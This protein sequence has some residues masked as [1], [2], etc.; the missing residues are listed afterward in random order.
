MYIPIWR[1]SAALLAMQLFSSAQAAVEIGVQPSTIGHAMFNPNPPG[2]PAFMQ[3]SVLDVLIDQNQSSGGGALLPSV[4]VNWDTNTQFTLAVSAPPGQKFLVKVPAGRS[5]GFGGFLWWESTRGGFSPSG[6]VA[7]SFDG[8]EGTPPLFSSSDSVL[9]DSHGFFGFMDLEGTLVT[10]DFA[11]TTLRL[12]GTVAPQVTG[13]GTEF[14]IPHMESSMQLYYQTPETNDPGRFVFIVP[15]ESTPTNNV[16]PVVDW[17]RPTN[18]AVFSAGSPIF[19]TVRATDADGAIN[20]VDFF[21]GSLNLGRGFFAPGS[22]TYNLV[23]S[24]A[25]AGAFQLHAEA[26]DN[27]GGQGLSSSVQIVVSGGTNAPP[28]NNVLPLVEWIRPTNGAA[29]NAGNPILLTAQATDADGSINFVEFFAGSLNLGRSS[30][31]STNGIYDLM[32]SNAP[33]GTFQLHAEA[34][35]NAGARGLSPSVQILVRANTNSPP[36]NNAVPVVTWIRPTNGAVFAAGSSI[37]LT[38]QATDTDGTVSFVDFFAGSLNLGRRSGTPSNELY[39][40]VWSNAPAGTF[41]LHAEA[42]DNAGGRGISS[43]VQIVVNGSTNPPPTNNVLP[44][45]E[46]I[47]P[48]SGSTFPTG[49]QIFMSARASDADGTINFVEFFAGSVKLGRGTFAFGSGLYNF[50]WSNAP[51]GMFQLRAEAVDNAGGRGVSASAPIVVVGTNAPATNNLIPVVTWVRPTNGAT[52]PSGTPITLT[53]RATDADGFVTLVDFFANSSYLGRRSGS[54]TNGLY[55]LLWSN[56]PP[57]SFTLRAEALD[58]FGGRGASAPVQVIVGITRTVV[59][60]GLVEASTIGHEF[61]A[62]FF[63]GMP[64]SVVDYLVDQDQSSG[65]GGV[66]PDV[67]VNWDTNYQFKLTVTAP[68]GQKFLVEVPPGRAAGF[69]GFLWWESTRGGFS[70]P[71]EVEASFTDLEGTPPQFTESDS[72]LSDSHGF[73]GFM[74]L[75]GTLVTNNFAFTSITLKGTVTPQYTGN[76]TETYLPHLHS[77]LAVYYSTPESTDPGRFVSIVPAGPLPR[78]EVVHMS[79][80]TGTVLMIY[81]RAGRTHVVECSPDTATWIPISTNTMPATICA[82][83]P[84]VAVSD[85]TSSMVGNRFYRVVELP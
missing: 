85:A 57:G 52:F 12:I 79:A 46:W 75:E 4:S 27:A 19:L 74:D 15:A 49:S 18:G 76:G 26:V 51:A 72:V 43:W 6:S 55:T 63:E 40:L 47:L 23:W 1:F 9:S 73:F 77:S 24:N 84:F 33:A 35:D 48:P 17:I 66:L 65:G 7:S 32:W 81:G 14:Y 8:L 53:A 22:G 45:V 13:N 28:T 82:I 5:V 41:Q 39:N 36:T 21:A 70:P 50:M 58:N 80:Q 60:L 64:K 38:A 20:F 2:G 71:G 69:S 54:P 16:L 61:F 78:L 31:I 37:V 29:F 62:P 44:V 34:V 56:P 25:P 68:P 59:D 42:V 10:N 3:R 11:F 67:S 30:G 83:C